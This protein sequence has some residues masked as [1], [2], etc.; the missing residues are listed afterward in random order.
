MLYLCLKCNQLLLLAS[1]SVSRSDVLNSWVC[2]RSRKPSPQFA[3]TRQAKW[4][5]GPYNIDYLCSFHTN[6]YRLLMNFN[7]FILISLSN[8][9]FL[10]NS[11]LTPSLTKVLCIS[12]HLP[13]PTTP[14]HTF[15]SWLQQWEKRGSLLK[16]HHI[17]PT[18]H[19]QCP[20]VPIS[21]PRFLSV[22]IF[23]HLRTLC[24]TDLQKLC[25]HLINSFCSQFF[26]RLLQQIIANIF[27]FEFYSILTTCVYS[28]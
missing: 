11:C 2:R 21:F 12:S 22:K 20:P 18:L 8:P 10:T 25:F 19:H 24:K 4:R 9:P 13:P 23:A 26:I 17:L 28:L 15:K 7:L 27:Q 3:K 16:I 14:K 5:E 6:M 1:S